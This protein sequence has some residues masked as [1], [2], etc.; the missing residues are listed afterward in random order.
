MERFFAFRPFKNKV[1][2]S[3]VSGKGNMCLWNSI[4]HAMTQH[5]SQ[6]DSECYGDVWY[7]R[8][9]LSSGYTSLSWESCFQTMSARSSLR[10]TVPK[11]QAA[12]LEEL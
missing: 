8:S 1:S 12:F 2:W 3:Q 10:G 5:G 4:Y 7:S 6:P 11:P 9:F